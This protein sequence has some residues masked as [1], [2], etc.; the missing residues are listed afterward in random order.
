[1][2]NSHCT[3]R[4]RK[5]EVD[6]SWAQYSVKKFPSK[7]KCLCL[8]KKWVSCAGMYFLMEPSCSIVGVMRTATTVVK[9]NLVSVQVPKRRVPGCC[10]DFNTARALA[11]QCM[12]GGTFFEPSALHRWQ[13]FN[14]RLLLVGSGSAT[15]LIK[16]QTCTSKLVC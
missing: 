5:L 13:I 7:P 16:H 6:S 8:C 12:Y 2:L 15:A 14:T 4:K 1:M 11:Q 3:V 9:P 10:T